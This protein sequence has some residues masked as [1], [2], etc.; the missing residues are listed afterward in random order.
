MKA[1]GDKAKEHY[2]FRK[3]ETDDEGGHKGGDSGPFRGI[4]VGEDFLYFGGW[5]FAI[6]GGKAFI[7]NGLLINFQLGVHDGLLMESH[8]QHKA[9]HGKHQGQ[10]REGIEHFRRIWGIL[11]RN[12]IEGK[13]CGVDG[14]GREKSSP[15]DAHGEKGLSAVHCPSVGEAGAEGQEEVCPQSWGSSS[16]AYK[17][18]ANLII[19]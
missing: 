11:M 19:I 13:N 3:S 6:G 14:D 8:G 2:G 17:L 18:G 10:R 5:C 7:D 12:E 16:E 15:E 4:C 9:H 1:W